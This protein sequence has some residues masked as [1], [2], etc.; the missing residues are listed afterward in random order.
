[1]NIVPKPTLIAV[2]LAL[3]IVCAPKAWFS[4]IVPAPGITAHPHN[5]RRADHTVN[6]ASQRSTSTNVRLLKIGF[7]V[8]AA[9]PK[10]VVRRRAVVPHP[11]ASPQENERRLRVGWLPRP[12]PTPSPTPVSPTASPDAS[13]APSPP[14]GVEVVSSDA[15]PEIN[16]VWLS[17]HTVRPGEAVDGR[18]IASSNVASVEVRLGGYS[19]VMRK[20]APGE[21]TLHYRVPWIA[22]FMRR[23]YTLQII[24]RNSSGEAVTSSTPITIH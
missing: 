4:H 23:T 20:V 6:T 18:V 16:S 15:Q 7:G 17:A 8:A 3:F 24:A 19:A 22:R 2:A 12:S 5:T 9:T 11:T 14:S 10:N 1:M 13:V 21:F